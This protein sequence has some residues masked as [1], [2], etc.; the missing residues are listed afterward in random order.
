MPRLT[1]KEQL[2]SVRRLGAKRNNAT[3]QLYI[4]ATSQRGA[5]REITL[6][7]LFA[8]DTGTFIVRPHVF[9]SKEKRTAAE[10]NAWLGKHYGTILRERILPG[11]SERTGGK[12]WR[13]YRP[14]GWINHAHTWDKDTAAHRT[15]HK[16]KRGKRKNGH[17]NL[18]RRHG[19]VRGRAAKPTVLQRA[20]K[21][22]RNHI[23]KHAR[24]HK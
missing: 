11:M 23:R 7:G 14:I 21:R 19:D 24:R 12:Q 5:W 17:N 22:K 10:W 8:S 15:R 20:S 9:T 13:L 16:T 2:L 4:K 18:R 6:F 1:I 3:G